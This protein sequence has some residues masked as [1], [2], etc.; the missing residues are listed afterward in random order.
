M[1]WHTK[2]T[3]CHVSFKH[4]NYLRPKRC[5]LAWVFVNMLLIHIKNSIRYYC[6]VVPAYIIEIN[7]LGVWF[8]TRLD[9]VTYHKAV[10]FIFRANHKYH[11]FS[12]TIH[13]IKCKPIMIPKKQGL[14]I[15][16]QG[17]VTCDYVIKYRFI[18]IP[19][20]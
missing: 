10:I 4:G 6:L 17:H 15:T 20:T 19:D 1:E 5:S 7:V 3:A 8:R 2:P 12:V 9:G 16:A 18:I 14:V 13:W 11:N